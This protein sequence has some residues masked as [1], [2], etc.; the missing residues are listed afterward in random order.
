MGQPRITGLT[1]EIR[2]TFQTWD[3]CHESIIIKYKKIY[4]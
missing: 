2:L 1:R 4:H 3:M